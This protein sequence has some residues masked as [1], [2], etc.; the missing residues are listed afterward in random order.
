MKNLADDI[1]KNI[2]KKFN[3]I[4]QKKLDLKNKN[5]EFIKILDS[6]DLHNFSTSVE[7]DMKKYTNNFNIEPIE[8]SR[9]Y[10]NFNILKKYLKKCLEK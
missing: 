5:K 6:L 10:K 4:S 2:V 7:E 1:L 3:R 8:F 9:K